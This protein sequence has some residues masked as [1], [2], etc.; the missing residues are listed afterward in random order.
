LD[1]VN[2]GSRHIA[3]ELRD[4][5]LFD[6]VKNGASTGGVDNDIDHGTTRA[7]LLRGNGNVQL[8][9]VD[10][11][12]VAER[13]NEIIVGSQQGRRVG[14]GEQ[15]ELNIVG[16]SESLVRQLEIQGNSV[17]VPLDFNVSVRSSLR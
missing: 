14:Q 3:V 11:K 17:G 4:A 9:G 15:L 6:K 10:V 7:L 1:A 13:G 5:T 16:A 8:L 12:K 2:S